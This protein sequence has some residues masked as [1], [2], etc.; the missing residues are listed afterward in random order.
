MKHTILALA[1][2]A[3]LTTPAWAGKGGPIFGGGHG[4]LATGGDAGAN[5][6]RPAPSTASPTDA[7]KAD[8][9]ARAAAW[10][11]THPSVPMPH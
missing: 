6:N 3:L 2:L 4:V 11:T 10:S 5:P 8:T 9:I 7:Q 1:T